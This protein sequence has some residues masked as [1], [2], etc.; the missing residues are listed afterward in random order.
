MPAVDPIPSV[1]PAAK[2]NALAPVPESKPVLVT[3]KFPLFKK[4]RVVPPAVIIA[5]PE[6]VP[7]QVKA[8]V[9]F[10][11][12]VALPMEKVSK[13]ATEK[14]L[15]IVMVLPVAVGWKVTVPLMARL[16]IVMVG[17]FVIG[18]DWSL[19]IMTSPPTTGTPFDQLLAVAQDPPV[20]GS[21]VVVCAKEF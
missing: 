15:E 12:A 4:V 3:V 10:N 16:L 9:K 7:V 8:N 1:A 13:A 14:V 19:L 20:V 5:V 11:L 17:M 6:I 21:Q 18:V 2:V